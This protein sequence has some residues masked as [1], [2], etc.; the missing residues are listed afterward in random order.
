M[1]HVERPCAYSMM[2][3]GP[4][5]GRPA[6]INMHTTDPSAVRSGN[7]LTQE[8][9]RIASPLIVLLRKAAA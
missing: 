5:A 6:I 4:I 7:C 3:M 2:R 8:T 1:C 9:D